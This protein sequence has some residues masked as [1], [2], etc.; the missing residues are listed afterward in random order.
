MTEKRLK[1]WNGRMSPPYKHG[2]V[3]AYSRADAIRVIAESLG[4]SSRGMVS[5]LRDYWSE[6]NWG[7]SMIGI[8]PERGLWASHTDSGPIGRVVKGKWQVVKT[9]GPEWA[10]FLAEKETREKQAKA[11]RLAAHQERC[12]RARRLFQGLSGPVGMDFG[13][14]KDVVT[15]EFLSHK[16]TVTEATE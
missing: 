9:R 8:V 13:I 7:N 14:A 16:F 15:I 4:Y 2:Y 10:E 12:D 1:L 3:A 11:A 6:G 5:E